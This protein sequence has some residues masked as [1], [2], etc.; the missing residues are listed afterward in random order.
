MEEA[1]FEVHDERG[2]AI[3]PRTI[4]LVA[5]TLLSE[6]IVGGAAQTSAEV[7][8]EQV[9]TVEA[10]SS[11]AV[12]AVLRAWEWSKHGYVLAFP[13][14]LANMGVHGV[15]PTREG[16]GRTPTGIFTLT[17]AFGSQASNGTKLPYF[18][19][20]PDDWWDEDPASPAYNRH[21]R[22]A[23]SP[24]GES[25]NLYDAGAVYAH[26]VVINYNTDPVV[27]GAGSGFFLHVSSGYPT[28]G[29]V[30]INSR[31]LN[32]IMRWL[33]PLD[34]PVISIGVG[35]SATA[36]VVSSRSDGPTQPLRV[37]D[38]S[39]SRV[40]ERRAVSTWARVRT[41]HEESEFAT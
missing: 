40:D 26:A 41:H 30:A 14:T 22:T 32:E 10:T 6:G 16:L 5:L 20:G 17:Q 35:S 19:A 15:G 9:I 11:R 38:Q 21:V 1:P 7:R 12:V 8:P 37:R 34:H 18:R 23:V 29:C 13:P 24:G 33:V 2:S 28:A 39:D 36:I 25:E 27:K 31:V 4:A 3:H